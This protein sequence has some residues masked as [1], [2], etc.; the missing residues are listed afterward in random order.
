MNPTLQTV[1]RLSLVLISLFAAATSPVSAT[2]IGVPGNMPTPLPQGPPNPELPGFNNYPFMLS[3]V[4]AGPSPNPL[5]NGLFNET[6]LQFNLV[7]VAGSGPSGRIDPIV[8]PQ[9]FNFFIIGDFWSVQAQFEYSPNTG[10]FHPSDVVTMTGD[11][12]HRIAPHP[13]EFAPGPAVP[14]N[15]VLNAGSVVTFPSDFD[16]PP[17][18]LRRAIRDANLPSGSRFGLD[19]RGAVHDAGPDSD[20]VFGILGGQIASPN[21]P[22]VGNDLEFWLGGVGG[23]HAPTPEPSTLLLIGPTLVAVGTAVLRWRRS[24]RGR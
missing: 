2:V 15:V 12:V 6:P 11:A 19:V 3:D 17:D 1:G 7:L 5:P 8:A 23:L 10:F 20:V 9:T 4:I 24:C 13:G 22:F 18:A 16:I 14:F 21:N